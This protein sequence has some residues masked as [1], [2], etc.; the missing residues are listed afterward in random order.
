LEEHL[1]GQADDE[2]A[3]TLGVLKT[4]VT[5]IAGVLEN[6]RD[7][8]S[9]GQL[10]R[11]ETDIPALVERTAVLIG[12]QAEQQGV[13]VELNMP[14]TD[15]P[16][17]PA[18][19]TRLEQ[20]LLNLVVN[21]LD[22]MPESGRLSLAVTAKDHAITVEVSDTGR[23]I[24]D[25]IRERIFDP[26]FTT[27]NDGS[28]MG[29]AVCDKIIRQHGGQIDVETSPAVTVFRITLPIEND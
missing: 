1:E 8:I 18:D 7:Y 22:E 2:T 20:V 29:L 5:R 17:I 27:K 9:L 3:E 4:E 19:A 10:N 11:A 14:R 12:P 21:A 24:P 25:N 23:G 15:L 16:S 28:G 6:F 26:Y 13:S